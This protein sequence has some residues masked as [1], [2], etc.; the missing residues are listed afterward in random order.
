MEDI[1]TQ[2]GA[3]LKGFTKMIIGM[4]RVFW[5]VQMGS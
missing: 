2:M 1:F 4:E 5:L 3:I